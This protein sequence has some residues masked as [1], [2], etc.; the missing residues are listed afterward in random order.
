MRKTI[1]RGILGGLMIL[2]L[3]VASGLPALAMNKELAEN[4]L[5]RYNDFSKPT[6]A[7]DVVCDVG[8][9]WN[10]ISN[11]TVEVKSGTN[12]WTILMGDDSSEKPSMTWL[13][14]TAYQN[15]IYLYF[16]SF[17]VGRGN[18]LVHFST[19]TSPGI[20]SKSINSDPTA[21]SHLDTYYKISDQSDLVP[22]VDRFNVEV[23]SRTYAWSETY[24]DDFIIYDYQIINLNSTPIDSIYVAL[25]ADCDV[26]GAGGGDGTQGFWRDDRVGYV[27][28]DTTKEYISYMYD[29]DNP[30]IAGDDTGGRFLPKESTGY[31]GS[32]L[33][34]CPPMMGSTESSVQNGSG[35]WDWNSD[36]G[37]DGDWMLLISDGR[38]LD[39]PPSPHDYRFLQ[40]LGPFEIAAGDS[41]RIVLAF[42]IGEG[43]AGLRANLEW[44]ARLFDAGWVGPSAPS[45]P[46]FSLAPGDREVAIEWDASAET[47]PDPATGEIDFEGY[48]V[49]RKTGTAGD[50]TLLMECDLING[51]G[52]NTGLVH[53]YLDA[54][55]NNGFQYSYV[56]TA[57]DR[58]DPA[59]GI[60]SFESG[61][62]GAQTVEPGLLVGTRNADA[63]GIHVVPNPF[64]KVSPGGF[65]FTP[66]INNPAEERLL[67]A[68][69]PAE[70]EATV[71]VYTL[72]GDEIV[73]LKKD[74]G[75]RAISWDLI[76]KST[77]KIVAGVY[78]Y[79]VESPALDKNFI[80]KFM[81]VR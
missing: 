69:L 11:S 29:S 47:T 79:V 42:G 19:D 77:Q 48:R 76:T 1:S 59:G 41:A 34:Y 81:V 80:G 63:S 66:D 28:N 44:G 65:G 71:T 15:N 20:D 35:W 72:T 10:R 46:V 67:F 74:P 49:W 16:A 12:D 26:S 2:G 45:T 32:R 22:E 30:T 53:S 51:L 57:Y 62:G 52:H 33:L 21:I 61:K 58:G 55:V 39:P 68:N 3:I 38:W 56:V 43:L 37:N 13:F 40:K 6:V 60:E 7:Q 31:I 50:W 17:R 4:P 78:L 23:H 25:H 75:V 73:K 27:R 18:K 54:D 24:R 9:V 36:P 64:V 14:P 70:G 8:S 5:L